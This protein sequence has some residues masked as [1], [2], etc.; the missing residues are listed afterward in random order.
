MSLGL[1]RETA[2]AAADALSTSLVCL[3]EEGADMAARTSRRSK[4]GATAE[5]LE[6]LARDAG[7]LAAAL[8]V[9]AKR[10]L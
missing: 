7:V 3:F 4:A 5:F 2:R 6:E 8:T 9:L 1:D 10:S